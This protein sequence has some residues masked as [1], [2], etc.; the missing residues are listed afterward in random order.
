M[1]LNKLKT[2]SKNNDEKIHDDSGN[3]QHDIQDMEYFPTNSHVS[4]LEF[5]II[6]SQKKNHQEL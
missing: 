4:L 3:R 1:C 6:L 5:T 2:S